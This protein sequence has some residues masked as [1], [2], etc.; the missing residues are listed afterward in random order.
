MDYQKELFYKNFV[1]RENEFSRAP[2]NPEIEF[3]TTIGAGNVERVKELCKDVLTDKPGLGRL[4][5]NP[6][7]NLK[8]HFV[9]TTALVARYCIQSGMDLSSAYSLSDFYIQKA[10]KCKSTED[11]SALHPIMCIDYAKR[12]RSLRKHAI[13]SKQ[14]AQCIDYIYDNLHAKITVEELAKLVDLNPNYLSRLF[15]KEVGATISSYIRT[16]KIETAKNM[17][18]FSDYKPAQISAILA[19]PSQSYF[20]EI[21][22]KHTGLTPTDY[23]KQVLN[24]PLLSSEE[25]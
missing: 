15:K 23:K 2:I 5:E 16:Q 21:F 10:D 12:M 7:Q 9:I 22:R 20:T 13:C 4:S 3:Y 24:R 8:Y 25:I 1:Q 17:L 19:F 6:L 18:R 14:I 11:I